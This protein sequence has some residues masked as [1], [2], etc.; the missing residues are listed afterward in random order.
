MTD[1][2]DPAVS[3]SGRKVHSD[4]VWASLRDAYLAGEA[5]DAA[6]SRHGVASATFWKR[7]R[8]E[9]W[10]RSDQPEA[11]P[12]AF[13]PERP[14]LDASDQLDLIDR[15]LSWALETGA[16]GEALRWMRMRER[17]EA[18]AQ[19]QAETHA[20][21]QAVAAKAAA[22]EDMACFRDLAA[23]TRALEQAALANKRRLRAETRGES[24]QSKNL[25]AAPDLLD[26]EAPNLSRAERRRRARY[27]ARRGP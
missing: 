13:D 15:R 25:A 7:A 6:A 12:P 4:A 26:P 22:R 16:A 10:R 14:A 11:P 5:G 9:G 1:T 17:I 8:R 23:A 19:R 2:S 3:T 21:L 24:G 20:R 18:R 27:L